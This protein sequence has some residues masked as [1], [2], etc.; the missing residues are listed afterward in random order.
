MEKIKAF[1]KFLEELCRTK[2]FGYF[3]A[4]IA[5]VG[6]GL[7]LNH[8][9]FLWLPVSLCGACGLLVYNWRR[10]DLPQVLLYSAAIV[11]LLF[12]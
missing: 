2:N 1:I 6:M 3:V 7:K 11:A 4:V 10:R 8:F 9:P 5:I 12:V